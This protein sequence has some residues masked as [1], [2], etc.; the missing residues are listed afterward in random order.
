MLARVLWGFSVF[1]SP[2]LHNARPEDDFVGICLNLFSHH[3]Q[4]APAMPQCLSTECLLRHYHMLRANHHPSPLLEHTP[5]NPVCL[6]C[7]HY[8]AST[9]MLCGIFLW[10]CSDAE[11]K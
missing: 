9:Y 3:L 7:Y 11:I 1:H 10:R 2:L 8:V 4:C 5:P 6:P